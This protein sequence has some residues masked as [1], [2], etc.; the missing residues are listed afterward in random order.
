MEGHISKSTVA[1]SLAR[2]HRAFG[3]LIPWTISSQYQDSDF[4]NLSGARIV[5]IATHPDAQ[6]LGYGSRALKELIAHFQGGGGKDGSPTIKIRDITGDDDNDGGGKA[7]SEKS[8]LS[9]KVKPRKL[10]APLLTPLEEKKSEALDWIGTSFGLTENLLG[11]W[12]RMEFSIV[13]LRQTTNDLTGEHTTIMLR[14]LDR[15]NYLSDVEVKGQ[16]LQEFTQD[17]LRRISRLLPFEFQGFSSKLALSVLDNLRRASPDSHNPVTP[18][19]LRFFLNEK[20]L[21][22]LLLYARNLVDYHMVKDLMPVLS[23]MYFMRQLPASTHLSHLMEVIL[24]GVGLQNHTI[25]QLAEELKLPGDQVLSVFNKVV[26]KIG[27]VLQEIH[28]KIEQTNRNKK[29]NGQA[30]T[31]GEGSYQENGKVLVAKNEKLHDAKQDQQE[32]AHKSGSSEK[33]RKEESSASKNYLSTDSRP[34][35][36]KKYKNLE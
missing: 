5:R 11:F 13:Y 32:K 23:Q 9:E 15:Q 18:T 35:K 24:V 20:D 33:K 14:K 16:W 12:N 27:G 10:I 30:S 6:R 34:P 1:N 17:A 22:R 19:Q 36:K 3:D 21:G 26:R 8:L 31:L 4:A 28:N 2:G 25:D 7:E 29:L